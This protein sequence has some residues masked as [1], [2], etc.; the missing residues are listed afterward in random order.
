[1][2]RA[3]VMVV[4]KAPRAGLVKTRL[5]PPLSARLACDVA[6]AALADTLEAVARCGVERRVL[7]LDGPVG[8]WLPAGF[9]VISQRGDSLAERLAC[10]WADTGGPGLQIGM[11]TPQVSSGLLDRCLAMLLDGRHPAALGPADDGGWWALGLRVADPR[12]FDGVP[13]STAR[14]GW[15]QRVRLAELGLTTATLP[16]L[17]DVDTIADAVAVAAAFPASRFAASV[18][19]SVRQPA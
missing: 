6:A 18:R 10:A 11:D 1:M 17:R 19:H 16:A 3:H 2:I 14:T 13:M 7:A 8:D 9:T 5:T 15:L 12:V 4:A